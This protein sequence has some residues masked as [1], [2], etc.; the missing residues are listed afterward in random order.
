MHLESSSSYEAPKL[1]TLYQPSKQQG[2]FVDVVLSP[3]GAIA[4]AL[5]G[6]PRAIDI[7]AYSHIVPKRQDEQYWLLRGRWA[8]VFHTG[9]ETPF[10]F[11]RV[12]RRICVLC[13]GRNSL[14][15]VLDGMARAYPSYPP[16]IV[17][18]D[19]V[20]FLFLLEELKLLCMT[21]STT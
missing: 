12:A 15:R 14:A 7:R 10:W 13:D 4:L 5:A 6:P 8:A 11:N 19:T 2:S 21:N 20:K 17:M 16:Q 1:A 18:K 9:L 3:D